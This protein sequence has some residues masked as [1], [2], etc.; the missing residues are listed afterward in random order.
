MEVRDARDGVENAFSFDRVRQS[1]ES[2]SLVYATAVQPLS[3]SPPPLADAPS[4]PESRYAGRARHSL[5][6]YRTR[7]NTRTDHF[8]PRPQPCAPST[9]RLPA[10]HKDYPADSK[11]AAA[12]TSSKVLSTPPT[13]RGEMVGP[14]PKEGLSSPTL[15][16]AVAAVLEVVRHHLF[17]SLCVDMWTALAAD[18]PHRGSGDPGG[19]EGMRADGAVPSF[20]TLLTG[21]ELHELPA[22]WVI[23]SV[24]DLDDLGD[25]VR[26]GVTPLDVGATVRYVQ[27]SHPDSED[28]PSVT[29]SGAKCASP[30]KVISLSGAQPTREGCPSEAADRLTVVATAQMA[31]G[32]YWVD[33]RPQGPGDAT[34]FAVSATAAGASV[35]R[36]QREA[37]ELDP[38]CALHYDSF[39]PCDE[40][41][42]NPRGT[43]TCLYLAVL[44]AVSR[45]EWR[46]GEGCVDHG[47]DGS[48]GGQPSHSHTVATKRPRGVTGNRDAPDSSSSFQMTSRP[49]QF[50]LA[51][52]RK[53]ALARMALAV[54]R[55]KLVT[56]GVIKGER[57]LRLHVRCEGEDRIVLSCPFPSNLWAA[58]KDGSLRWL[59]DKQ[60]FSATDSGSEK[61]VRVELLAR[62][63]RKLA[64]MWDVQHH[65][66]TPAA[67]FAASVADHPLRDGQGAASAVVGSLLTSG[68]GKSLTIAV[69]DGAVAAGDGASF[70]SR[71]FTMLL[72]YQS[73]LGG[74]G[75]NQGPHAAVPPQ[76]LEEMA[77]RFDVCVEAFASPLNAQFAQFGSLFPDTDAFFG[78]IGSFFDTVFV[79]GHV[80]VNPPFDSAVLQRLEGHLLHQLQAASAGE[81]D[82][83][84]LFVVVLPSHDLDESEAGA[85]TSVAQRLSSFR[86]STMTATT[87]P[88]EHGN[89]R[90]PPVKRAWSSAF[91][92]A[93]ALTPN[94]P[95]KHSTER[96]L[97]ESSFCLAHVLCPAAES[98]YVDGHQHILRAPLFRITTPTRL[99]VLGNEAAR[100]L[101]PDAPQ[102]LNAV[103]QAWSVLTASV[104]GGT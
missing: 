26:R 5:L 4:A 68:T 89:A 80:E 40:A 36:V 32:E 97:R 92:S 18:Q 16:P 1:L 81:G 56:P 88:T 22:R 38:P 59:L 66:H 11:H 49:T 34:T 102:R 39:L 19:E 35:T 104:L 13:S 37:I 91:S 64:A 10:A 51:M 98:A 71:L 96:V 67:P 48:R 3:S 84:L 77:T 31:R 23:Q 27:P 9:E 24:G 28:T 73:L 52:A 72:R 94:T 7:P 65:H 76:V 2:V 70:F 87:L 93:S 46:R 29:D 79:S 47:A 33:V 21:Q 69:P 83:S 62:S 15:T 20:R 50:A 100:R 82:H 17:H 44:R 12:K 8:R 42:H 95:A 101:Y 103:R 63:T 41:P 61:V 14:P 30:H 74:K 85:Q 55:G 86:E 60:P 57:P 99:I 45:Q 78:S 53:A 25:G 43:S 54:A 75:Y 90:W 58:E 6:A